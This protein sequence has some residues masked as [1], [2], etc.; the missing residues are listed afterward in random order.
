VQNGA[1]SPPP[2]S[3]QHAA[4]ARASTWDARGWP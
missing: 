2:R 3:Q 4:S 1:A